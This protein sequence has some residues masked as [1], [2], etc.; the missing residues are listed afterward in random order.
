MP[1]RLRSRLL[2]PK[3]FAAVPV[4]QQL[5]M[6]SRL[7]DLNAVQWDLYPLPEA[8]LERKLDISVAWNQGHRDV[9]ELRMVAMEEI[10]E[11]KAQVTSL[12]ND[13]VKS[14]EGKCKLDTM[15]S[16]QQSPNDKSGLGFKSNNKNKSKNNY[17]KKGQVQ[18][19]DPAKIVCFKC[20]IEGHHVRSCPLKKKQ[21]GK[22]PQAQTHIQPQVEEMQLPK[23]NQVNA[24]IVEKSSERKEKK[25]TCY[26]CRE[27][28]HISSFCTIGTSS[29]SITIDDVYSLRKDEGGNVFAKFVGAQSGVKK[30]TIW[31]AKPI[32]TNLLGPNLVGDKQ[33]K[34]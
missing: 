6:A 17:K 20:N 3:P 32:V 16:V 22:R 29:N 1:G 10:K 4:M 8:L 11:L 14:H 34:T 23:K 28:G 18:V 7:V 5:D 31:V 9:P 19:K 25:R 24:P 15:L 30:I 12:K 13:L 33:S 2:H 27:K 26:I 21:K